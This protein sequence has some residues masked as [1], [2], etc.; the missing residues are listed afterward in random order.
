MDAAKAELKKDESIRPK[1]IAIKDGNATMMFLE[2]EDKKQKEIMRQIVTKQLKAMQPDEY[3]FISEA[4]ISRQRDDRV[5][6]EP[7]R[8][9]DR[10]EA[11]MVM[12][13]HRE[14]D[15]CK[16]S[17]MMF[18]KVDGKYE[19]EDVFTDKLQYAGSAWDI[20]HE[21]DNLVKGHDQKVFRKWAKEIK[22]ELYPELQAAKTDEQRA[23]LLKKTIQRCHEKF[24]EQQKTILEDTDGEEGG[25]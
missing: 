12:E 18:K 2:F 6:R 8:D 5:Y 4:W 24:K 13:Y 3:Y 7:R 22:A 11:I 10:M 15:K 14:M 19:F 21:Q 25:R 23:A 17:Q 1:I 9:I 16:V 20:W